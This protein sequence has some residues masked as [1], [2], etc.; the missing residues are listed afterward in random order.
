M[1]AAHQQQ[2]H[3]RLAVGGAEP[4]LVSSEVAKMADQTATCSA[5]KIYQL[6]EAALACKV[7]DC[8]PISAAKLAPKTKRSRSRGR[9]PHTDDEDHALE[10]VR[11]PLAGVVG[12]QAGLEAS[13]GRKELHGGASQAV[14][15]RQQRAELHTSDE[16]TSAAESS[17][18]E[19][20]ELAGQ[21]GPTGVSGEQETG[22]VGPL[23]GGRLAASLIKPRRA[24]T[25]FT[26]EQI[27]ALEQKFKLTR[28]LSVFERSN[29]A[30]QLKL[31]ETQVK[32]WFQNR[33]TKWKKQNPGAE[34]ISLA[35]PMQTSASSCEFQHPNGT[36]MGCLGHPSEPLSSQHRMPLMKQNASGGSGNDSPLCL[37]R[38]NYSTGAVYSPEVPPSSGSLS[39][40]GSS[41]GSSQGSLLSVAC[42]T[43]ANNDANR[44]TSSMLNSEA[45]RQEQQTSPR[46]AL[47]RDAIHQ[48]S[49]T[50]DTNGSANSQRLSSNGFA[51]PTEAANLPAQLDNQHRHR[52]N[53]SSTQRTK[54]TTM[55]CG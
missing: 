31:T 36:Q 11:A 51:E 14:A 19:E 13:L 54:T 22:R 7:L 5:R 23:S 33:R 25:A 9:Y 30:A 20:L 41:E 44:I 39:P 43:A 2:Q 49:Q 42:T 32:I 6:Q 15:R 34:T 16:E 3:W 24:R 12:G 50:G 46:T 53:H 8:S 37:P 38:L 55:D 35:G 18:E 4:S 27:S 52:D 40:A 28:Y 1:A 10:T 48:S 17:D 29:L 45:H 26:Y 47:R 21:E